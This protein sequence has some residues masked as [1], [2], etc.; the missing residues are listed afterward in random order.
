MP[1]CLDASGDLDMSSYIPAEDHAALVWMN[2]FSSVMTSSPYTYALSPADAVAI[3]SAVAAYAAALAISDDD[4]TRTKITIAAKDDARMTAEQMCRK[5]AILIKA[6]PGIS[7]PDKL[8]AGVR[9][10]NNSRDPIEVPDT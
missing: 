10:V 2:Q 1:R 6:N 4:N 3:A 8:A 5:Y 9:P 7:D